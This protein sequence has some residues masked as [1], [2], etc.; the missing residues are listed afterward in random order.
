MWCDAA[1][2]RCRPGA[3]FLARDLK[4]PSKVPSSCLP[5]FFVAA[6]HMAAHDDERV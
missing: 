2:P 4:L 5:P 1:L 6:S 3:G